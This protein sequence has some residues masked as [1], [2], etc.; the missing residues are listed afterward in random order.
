MIEQA[1]KDHFR[2]IVEELKEVKTANNF[3]KYNIAIEG[4]VRT[5]KELMETTNNQ[6][7]SLL[8]SMVPYLDAL[9]VDCV[10]KCAPKRSMYFHSNYLIIIASVN[11]INQL[12]MIFSFFSQILKEK[13]R[14]LL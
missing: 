10:D 7:V 12:T 11:K 14:D 6:M 1:L 4:E 9:T 13:D 3:N 5:V 8:D 2:K